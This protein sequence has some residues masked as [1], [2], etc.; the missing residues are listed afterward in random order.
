MY[1]NNN[2]LFK[3]VSNLDIISNS[4]LDII[5]YNDTKEIENNEHYQGFEVSNVYGIISVE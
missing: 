4:N 2:E 5:S 1:Q 3:N